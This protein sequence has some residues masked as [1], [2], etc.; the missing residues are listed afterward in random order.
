MNVPKLRFKEFTDEW[1]QTPLKNIIYSNII[2]A[3]KPTT[4]YIRLGI[5]SHCKGTFHELVKIENILSA[6]KM[7]IVPKNNLIL[8]ITFAWEQAIAITDDN[9]EGKYISNRF[10]T[11]AFK[12]NQLPTFYKYIIPQKRLKY[13]LNVASPGGAGRN[14]VLNKKL[15]L[16]I[17][18]NIPLLK[19][20]EKISKFL[21]TV[22]KKITNLKNT[23]TSL[24]NQKK[25]LLQQIF[26]QKLRFKDENG[27]NYPNWEKKK[28]EDI[29]NIT[30]GQSPDSDFVNTE[31]IGTPFLQGNAEFTNKYPIEKYWCTKPQKIANPTDILLSVRAPV[32]A[33]NIANKKF[34]IGRG[35]SAISFNCNKLFGKYNLEFNLFQLIKKSQGSTF[36][37]INKKDISEV[38]LFIPC[39]E[40]QT[41]IA[42]F[43]SAFDRKL[44]NQKAQL[45]HWKQIKK[46]LLQQMFV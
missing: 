37:S 40:E 4:D 46:G 35:L 11:F 42:D 19:E 12:D 9:D 8:N 26:S 32:G 20:Q 13:D 44:E 28:L 25:G 39:L 29:S 16:S 23:I 18:V 5:R 33:I 43:L 36:S 2:E 24:E 45:E 3:P 38:I 15:F 21:T 34:C 41:K 30:M 22:D 14:R 6:D 17:P 1:K 10:P 7:Y 31:K 27:N